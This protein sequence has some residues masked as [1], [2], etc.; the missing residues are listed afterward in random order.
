MAG[1]QNPD[2]KVHIVDAVLFARKAVLSPTVQMAHIKDLEKGTAKYPIRPVDCKVYSIPKGAMS[3][4]HE[5][6]FLGTLPK[7]LILWCIDND[8][9]N[10]EH[11]KN[12]FNA[13]NNAINFLAA[14]VDGVRF[15]RNRSSQTLKLAATFE[16][17]STCFPPPVNNH[18]TKGTDCRAMT[19]VK[20]TPF[21]AS[22]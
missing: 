15:R 3:H 1:G 21:S 13:K 16:A 2:Y 9:Y 18:R 6:L 22:I 12:P 20:A 17:T 10:G 11:S 7:R 5:N 14:Y 19:L 8:A 4:T